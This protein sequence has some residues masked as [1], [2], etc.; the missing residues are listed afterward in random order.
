MFFFFFFQILFAKV[1][2]WSK[3]KEFHSY[4]TSARCS[5]KLETVSLGT[6]I[7]KWCLKWQASTALENCHVPLR[8]MFQEIWGWVLWRWIMYFREFTTK[9]DL[10]TA[11]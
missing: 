8:A 1:K 9:N 10:D 3:V 11:W 2:L 6:Q 5:E 4:W 7:L